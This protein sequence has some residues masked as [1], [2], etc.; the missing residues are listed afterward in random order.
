MW[1]ITRFIQELGSASCI[2]AYHI[3]YP[4]YPE[5]SE[6]KG[7]LLRNNTPRTIKLPKQRK[8]SSFWNWHCLLSLPYLW[9]N[10]V[11]QVTGRL[12]S[13]CYITWCLE[14][15]SRIVGL[16]FS[17]L[18][19]KCLILQMFVWGQKRINL[20][21]NLD[22]LQAKN[23]MKRDEGQKFPVVQERTSDKVSYF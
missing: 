5:K 3:R 22:K 13:G 12:A 15:L 1:R 9:C 7:V 16:A 21:L 17:T 4:L 8:Q 20:A 11:F 6:Y 10:L 19:E 14:S 2:Q 23:E 18:K